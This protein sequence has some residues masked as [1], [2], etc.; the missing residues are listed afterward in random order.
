MSNIVPFVPK[1]E[2]DATKNLTDF[3]ALCRERLEIFGKDL[4]WDA[5]VWDVSDNVERRGR[6]GRTALVWTNHDTSK[7]QAGQIMEQPFLDFAK[8]YMRYQHGMRPTNSVALRLSALRALERALSNTGGM[9]KVERT[10]AAVLNAAALLLQDKFEETTAY[11]IGTQLNMI[12]TFLVS[13]KLTKAGFTWKSPIP[14]PGERNRIG[15]KFDEDRAKRMPEQAALDA[16]AAAF[17]I[18]TEPVDVLVASVGAL[19]CSAPDRINELFRLPVDCEVSTKQEN[20]DES[21]GLRWWPSK[22]AE[23]MVKGIVGTMAEVAKMAVGKIR[24]H[25]EEARA[26]ARWYTTNPEKLFLPEDLKR[27][28]R[29]EYV[30]ADQLSL[31]LGMQNSSKACRWA[32]ELRLPAVKVRPAGGIGAPANS[33]RFEDIERAIVAM[34]PKGFP[35]IDQETGLTYG[36]A[37]F[38]VPKN[39]F[40]ATRGTHR[41]MFEAVTTDVINNQFGAG[42]QHGKSSLFSRL[43]LKDED[44]NYPNV[45]THQFRHWL[46]TLAQKGGLSQMDIAK[47]SGRKDVQQN[48]AYDHVTADEMI[49]LA[50]SIGDGA[51]FGPLAEFVARAP[52]S[53]DEYLKMKF[54]TAHTTELGFCIHDWIMLPCQRHL[55]CVNCTEHVCLKGDPRKTARIRQSLADAEEQLARASE[56]VNEEFYGA[57]RW[58]VHHRL[59]VERLRNLVDILDDPQVPQGAVIQLAIKNEFS[60]IGSAVDDR[61]QLGDAEAEII[62]RIRETSKIAGNGAATAALPGGTS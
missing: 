20:G 57:D 22:G 17:C 4:V 47:W 8:A 16:L 32:N 45:T 6:K 53:R 41:C 43:D 42:H 44:G 38:V 28:R 14:R 25:T 5:D 29:Q 26:M 52:V 30:G 37:L 9:A 60:Q 58:L 13:N 48:A 54:P 50:R 46:N 49:A 59:T 40:H 7:Q 12:A 55:D 10:D 31:L 24:K 18:A 21:Y 51:I 2:H 56:G 15:R 23:P 27:L 36:D 61:Q 35:T 3:I 1:A 62:K 39:F 33:Y 19:L 11:R 34:L